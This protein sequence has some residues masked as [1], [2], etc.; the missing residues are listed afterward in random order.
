MNWKG[1]CLYFFSLNYSVS[2]TYTRV[3]MILIRRR[4]TNILTLRSVREM[5]RCSPLTLKTLRW[6]SCWT[7]AHV[8]TG[9]FGEKRRSALVVAPPAKV[10]RDFTCPQMLDITSALVTSAVSI[11]T[12]WIWGD[13]SSH[14]I[15]T[16]TYHPPRLA[17]L[18]DHSTVLL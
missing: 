16:V 7:N 8:L 9:D 5:W 2:D 15:L 13:V 3:V 4:K 10:F 6:C 11:A 1:E 17:M 18:Q 12:F 14:V